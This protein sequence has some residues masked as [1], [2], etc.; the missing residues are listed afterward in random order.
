MRILHGKVMGG[1]RS[2]AFLLCYH[3]YGELKIIITSQVLECTRGSKY[4]LLPCK[5]S[6]G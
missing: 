2:S 5:T 3:V 4:I 1:R 6:G